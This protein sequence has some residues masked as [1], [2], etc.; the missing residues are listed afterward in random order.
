ME[1]HTNVIPFPKVPSTGSHAGRPLA[2]H[3]AETSPTRANTRTIIGGRWSET[4]HLPLTELRGLI[5][6]DI[7]HLIASGDIPDG[8]YRIDVNEAP[9]TMAIFIGVSRLE[10]DALFDD[11]VVALNIDHVFAKPMPYVS[12]VV[13][14]MTTHLEAVLHQ[15]NRRF[16]R[17]DGFEFGGRFTGTVRLSSRFIWDRLCSEMRNPLHH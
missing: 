12:P 13:V 8:E 4:Q 17:G 1:R 5:G 3:D 14:K 16:V 9:Y 7:A 15:Y 10:I 6:A 11:K 2:S